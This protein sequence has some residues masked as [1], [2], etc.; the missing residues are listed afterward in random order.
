MKPSD[1][2]NSQTPSKTRPWNI[3]EALLEATEE[4]NREHPNDPLVIPE[5]LRQAVRG[6]DQ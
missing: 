3:L 5:S 2:Q 6:R 1:K 4:I